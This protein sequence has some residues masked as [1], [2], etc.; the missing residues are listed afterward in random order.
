VRIDAIG[1]DT[2]KDSYYGVIEE[3]WELDYGSLKIPLFHRQ[4]V[5]QAGGGVTTDRYW[6]TIV[7]FKK[8][9][10]KDE[11]FILAKDVTHVF[12]VKDMSSK[13]KKDMSSKSKNDEPNHH[14]VLPRKRK[15]IGV[16]VILDKS[17]DFYQFDDL[18]LSVN[19][20]LASYREQSKVSLKPWTAFGLKAEGIQL[21]RG[22][23]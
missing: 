16:E 13:P 9:G 2:K 1:N 10:Y 17:E 4:W 3:I 7:D 20:E 5:N 23:C 14:I 12:Y 22:A 8:I 11:P 6:M 18:L 19:V 15:I 21:N